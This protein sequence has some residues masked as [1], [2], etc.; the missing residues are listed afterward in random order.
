MNI[1]KIT[2]I[3]YGMGNIASVCNAFKFLGC[4]VEVTD[5]PKKIMSA[6]KLVLPGVGSFRRAEHQLQIL[7]IKNVI[8]DVVVDRSRPILGI[9]LGMQLLAS[10]S[11]EDGETL[12]LGI[13]DGLIDKFNTSEMENR[14]IP[15]VGFNEVRPS[16]NSRLFKNLPAHADFYF[17]HSYRISQMDSNYNPSMCMYGTKFVAA[18]EYNNVFGTQFH[19]EKSQTNGL[20]LLR[21]F[22]KA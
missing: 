5:D 18:F 21:N 4:T 12:G 14:K 20:M 10:K 1:Q 11:T 3:D 17:V 2:I 9:C 16:T 6:E 13:V 22:L 7:G 8:L 19:P 15:H